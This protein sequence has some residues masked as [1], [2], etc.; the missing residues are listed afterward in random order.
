MSLP[1]TAVM[2]TM[3]RCAIAVAWFV[4]ANCGWWLNAAAQT[5][6]PSAATRTNAASGASTAVL[7]GDSNEPG[8]GQDKISFVDDVRPILERHCYACHADRKQKSGLRLD[9]KSAAMKGGESHGPA[10]VPNDPGASPLWERIVSRDAG[11]RMPPEGPGLSPEESSV[12]ERWIALGAEWPDGVDRVALK[13]PGQHWSFQPLRSFEGEQSIDGWIQSKLNEHGLS[14]SPEA[15]PAQW[16]RRVTL[17]LHGLPVASET[18]DAFVNNPTETAYEQAVEA[19]LSSPRYAERWAQHWLDVVRYA[20]THGF[21]VNTERPHAWHYRD[22]VIEALHGDTPYDRFVR[23]QIAGDTIDCDP[24]TGFL[25]TASVLL[26]GQIGA[27]EP[28]KRLARQDAID[29]IVVNIGQTFLGLSIGCARCHDHKFDPVTQ[30]DYYAM[31][32][33]VAGVEYGDR[34]MRTPQ[35]REHERQARE[36]E[37]RMLDIDAALSRLEPIARVERL[38][39]T[40]ETDPKQNVETFA[41]REVQ[42][43]RFEIAATNLHPTLG[44]IEPCIDEFEIWTDEPIPRNIAL[45][46]LGT[47]VTASGSRNS[48][49]H[50]L[51]HVNDGLVG[52][53]HSWM[54]DEAGRGWLLFE[55]QEPTRV[56]KVVW[57]RD[58]LGQFGDR[59]ATA[60]RIT[61]GLQI[62]GMD[63][64]IAVGP[65]RPQVQPKKNTER[66]E[67]TVAKR[68]RFTIL[69]TNQLEPC[70]DE[71]EV[72]SIEGRNVAM[73]SGGTQVASSGDRIDP[74][75]HE[76]RFVNDGRYGNERS[77]MSD[78]V[79]GGSL[80]FEFPEATTIDRIVWGRDR[81]G[82]YSDRLPT[83][84][85]IEIADATGEWRCIAGSM[86]RQPYHADAKPSSV[87]GLASF[88]TSPAEAAAAAALLEER[89]RIESMRAAAV[90]SQKAFAG[91][92]RKPD[93]IRLLNR[94]DPE[95]PRDRVPPN[96]PAFMGRLALDESSDDPSR[97]RAL[98]DWIASADHPLTARVMVNRIWQGHFGAGLVGTPNDFGLNGLPPSHPELLDYLAGE[99]V[100]M[101]W[102][103]KQLHRRIVLSKT[104]R[105]SSAGRAE[106]MAIDA[107][108]RWLWRYPRRR[109]ES[110]GIRDCMLAV[111]GRLNDKMFGRGF[112][113]FDQ[114]GGLS[115][116]KP[117]ESYR[118]EG[119]RRMIYAHKVRREREAVFGAFDCPDAG[120]ST[121]LR[122]VSTTPIQALNLF[123]SRFTL[124]QSEAM[125]ERV[126]SMAGDES[127]QQVRATYRLA[128]G[129][130]AQVEEIAE[131]VPVVKL[132]GLPVLCRALFN[133]S[134]F[135]YFP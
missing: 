117:V 13:D 99:F 124:E 49:S 41:P 70:I 74:D 95:Q 40:R 111:S 75:R 90:E 110:E 16:L 14:M 63:E 109:L 86:D 69:A 112:D 36:F 50:Q 6:V 26:P 85:C 133:S 118:D 84:Y 35:A 79:G 76:L 96:V 129:R 104:Y 78:Q 123:N 60:Y 131:A 43:V 65:R 134:E 103:M 10:I 52:N 15:T 113:L 73:A 45:A 125:A 107:D 126:R 31:Q 108:A 57:G 58:R 24:A 39:S 89:T 102:S 25:I 93:D 11:D 88:G 34:V 20:D 54:S 9:V 56:S 2:N 128:L 100:R 19:L 64:W 116:F 87:W 17:D 119:L 18:L 98:A 66:F 32:A 83:E 81:E 114:R 80:T 127:E 38:P 48:D 91:V 132:H 51:K 21:E 8:E 23:E 37:Q 47:R 46:T 7:S 121:A 55:L 1:T 72:F 68:L 77:W 28:S 12:I 61:G 130:E 53:A 44:I 22:Y 3:R 94:G 135:L 122:R 106:A 120:Q 62:D 67:P 5:P 27:D 42:W 33:L 92:F 101:G 82:R 97:R 115:G 71:F 4:S 105:Q 29:E 59:L 30:R